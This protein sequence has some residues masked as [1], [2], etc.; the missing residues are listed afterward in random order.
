[1][2]RFKTFTELMEGK[3]DDLRQEFQAMPSH[4]HLVDLDDP[5][6]VKFGQGLKKMPS[7]IIS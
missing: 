6:L 5:T 2:L 3:A 7:N 4:S 1:M